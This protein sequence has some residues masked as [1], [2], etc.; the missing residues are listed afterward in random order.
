MARALLP[1]YTCAMRFLAKLEEPAYAALRAISGFLF[2]F[3]GVQKLFG[4]LTTKPTPEL[5][6]Q[7]WFGGAIEL[8]CGVLI[9]L[10]LGTRIAAFLASGTMAVAYFQFH[11]KT[12]DL[13]NWQ[14]LPI[15]NGGEL[16]V[17]YCFVFLFIAARG[18]GKLALDNRVR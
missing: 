7:K 1:G 12:L 13:S 11:Q 8:D 3:H 17:M 18:P 5:F 10:G 16:A 9:M 15:K 6:S 4:W 2:A 14:W